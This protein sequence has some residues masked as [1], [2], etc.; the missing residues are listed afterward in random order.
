MD[1][2]W[3]II[4]Y[5]RHTFQSGGEARQFRQ[6]GISRRRWLLLDR[7]WPGAGLVFLACRHPPV[8]G[9][10]DCHKVNPHSQPRVAITSSSSELSHT[11]PDRNQQLCDVDTMRNC[12]GYPP[13][14]C[15]QTC[16]TLLNLGS[17]GSSSQFTLLLGCRNVRRPPSARVVC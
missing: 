6:Y 13:I 16:F 17:F 11:A 1:L 9:S 8:S 3:K 12:T 15:V 14:T 7:M 2:L 10:P 4:R 5:A